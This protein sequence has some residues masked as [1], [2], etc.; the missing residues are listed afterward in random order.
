MY[1]TEWR[2]CQLLLQHPC[3]C[4]VG[5]LSI[6]GGGGKNDELFCCY[7]SKGIGALREISIATVFGVGPVA[8]AY[9]YASIIP[10]FFMSMLGGINGPLHTSI[11]TVV[12]KRSS[13]NTNLLIQRARTVVLLALTPISLLIFGTYVCHS[14]R[15]VL[16]E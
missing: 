13:E 8:D 1:E 2:A 4:N 10:S 11:T 9:S 3:D 12:S 6:Q 14:I 16:G 5:N 15:G 7:C